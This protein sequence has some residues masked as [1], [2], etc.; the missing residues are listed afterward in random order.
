MFLKDEFYRIDHDITLNFAIACKSALKEPRGFALVSSQGFTK[1][2]FASILNALGANSESMFSYLRVKGEIEKSIMNLKYPLT[3]ILRPGL[4]LLENGEERKDHRFFEKI[5]RKFSNFFGNF[6]GI[7]TVAVANV[8]VNLAVENLNDHDGNSNKDCQ[9][10]ILENN[11]I[12]N[13]FF[14]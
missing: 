1:C 11:E 9:I 3:V 5:A 12:K 2:F 4:L 13:R 6:Y 7:P 10:I 8:M 14:K